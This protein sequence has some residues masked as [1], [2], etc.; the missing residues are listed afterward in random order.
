[1][2]PRTRNRAVAAI[3]SL[4]LVVAVLTATASPSAAYDFPS[5]ND[6][7]RTANLPHVNLVS[8]GPGTVTLEFPHV[9]RLIAEN[10][11]DTIYHE[12]FSYFSLVTIDMMAERHG[13]QLVDVEELPTHGGSL[14]VYLAHEEAKRPVSTRVTDLIARER[15]H[16]LT[17]KSTYASFDHKARMAKRDLLAFLI[18][19]K[20]EGKKI[21]GKTRLAAVA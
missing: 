4:A 7:N 12:H 18:S 6:A 13:L 8:T 14:R 17:N 11:F 10:Q 15:L 1:M 9:E 19:A 16:G 3:A 20:N 5:T 21:C 2:S